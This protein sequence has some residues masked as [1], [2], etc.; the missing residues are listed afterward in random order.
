MSKPLKIVRL[1]GCIQAHFDYSATTPN[2]TIYSSIPLPENLDKAVD[3]RKVEY[4]AG[5]LC[6][7]EALLN[8]GYPNYIPSMGAKREPL[9]PNGVVGSI[10]HS[11]GMAIAM[12]ANSETIS[13]I[14]IDLEKRIDKPSPGLIKQ[15]CSPSEWEQ[16]DTKHT[17]AESLTIIFSSKEALYKALY[18]RVG[19]FF[20]FQAAITEF[21]ETEGRLRLRLQED[22]SPYREG[23]TFEASW[24]WQENF[25][26]PKSSSPEI[27]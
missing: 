6:A 26:L 3:K 24:D 17:D 13:A 12:V 19:K 18:P 2:S 8:L 4:L 20:G 16:R 15:I 1:E 25:A 23:D 14:G 21:F 11:N 7:K 10:S 5:R 22:L 9:W 27:R